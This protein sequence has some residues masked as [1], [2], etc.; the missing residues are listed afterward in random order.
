M[1]DSEGKGGGG[2]GDGVAKG[3]EESKSVD[4]G[5]T[6]G[7]DEKLAQFIAFTGTTEEVANHW[8]EVS[9]MRKDSSQSRLS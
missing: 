1:A 3:F 6:A 4:G 2:G 8:L 5:G 7:Q 9:D